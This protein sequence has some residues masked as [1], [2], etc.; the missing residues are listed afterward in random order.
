MI[1]RPQRLPPGVETATDIP[2]APALGAAAPGLPGTVGAGL[3]KANDLDSQ[4]GGVI[5]GALRKAARRYHEKRRGPRIPG[6]GS[7]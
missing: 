3:G 4:L 1:T 2:S 7:F 6:Q 5:A